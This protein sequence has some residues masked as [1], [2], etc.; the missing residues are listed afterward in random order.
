MSTLISGAQS[1]L[2]SRTSA[3][4]RTRRSDMSDVNI[5]K[6]NLSDLTLPKQPLNRDLKP[7]D[8]APPLRLIRDL[9]GESPPSP[10]AVLA[11]WTLTLSLAVSW[12]AMF[13]QRFFAH[14][15]GLGSDLLDYLLRRPPLHLSA[16]GT[17]TPFLRDYE[18]IIL[19]IIIATAVP[20]VYALFLALQGL[21]S[22]LIDNHC[23]EI[24]GSGNTTD[25]NSDAST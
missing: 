7:F 2:F 8:V 24:G 23:I 25:P 10:W 9:G 4:C 17:F 11:V 20:L 3:H 16:A 21:H 13:E 14:G 1:S 5:P 15:P 19:A 6:G 12:T 22:S 18:S